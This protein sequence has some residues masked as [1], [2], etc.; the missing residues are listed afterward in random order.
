MSPTGGLIKNADD[1][2]PSNAAAFSWQG[3]E[4]D[5]FYEQ[6]YTI[7]TRKDLKRSIKVTDNEINAD[8]T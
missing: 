8:V 6:E 1:Q 2:G 7:I 5:R 3:K 4:T